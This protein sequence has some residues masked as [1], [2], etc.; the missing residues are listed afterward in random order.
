MTNSIFRS[1][2]VFG[3]DDTILSSAV[4]SVK[5]AVKKAKASGKVQRVVLHKKGVRL[6]LEIGDVYV[7]PVSVCDDPATFPTAILYANLRQHTTGEGMVEFSMGDLVDPKELSKETLKAFKELVWGDSKEPLLVFAAS[8]S[9][10]ADHQSFLYDADTVFAELRDVAYAAPFNPSLSSSFDQLRAV[11]E[12]SAPTSK[13]FPGTQYIYKVKSGEKQEYP[14]MVRGLDLA[15]EEGKDKKSSQTRPT[16][17]ILA[18]ELPKTEKEKLSPDEMSMFANLDAELQTSIVSAEE[19]GKR[20]LPIYAGLKLAAPAP[21]QAPGVPQVPGQQVTPA[22]SG[23]PVVAPPA[24]P[25][26]VAPVQPTTKAQP[27][28]PGAPTNPSPN[29]VHTSPASGSNA[30]TATPPPITVPHDVVGSAKKA[31]AADT[32]HAVNAFVEEHAGQLMSFSDLKAAFSK[33]TDKIKDAVLF[34]KDQGL[35]V[36]EGPDHVKIQTSTMLEDNS[37]VR[38]RIAKFIIKNASGQVWASTV[39]EGI[40]LGGEWT[41]DKD[42]GTEFENANDAHDEVRRHVL[43]S[44][45]KVVENKE[46]GCH[47]CKCKKANRKMAGDWFNPGSVLDTFYP[48]LRQEPENDGKIEQ[49]EGDYIN[50]FGAPGHSAPEATAGGQ[51]GLNQTPDMTPLRQENNFY[52]PEFARNFY[53]PHADI[54]G[55][56]LTPRQSSKKTA[57]ENEE[58]KQPQVNVTIP[59]GAFSGAGASSA[60]GAA[61]GAGEAAAGAA[62]ALESLAPLALLASGKKADSTSKPMSEPKGPNGAPAGKMVADYTNGQGVRVNV[63]KLWGAHNGRDYVVQSSNTDSLTYLTT[64]QAK[65]YLENDN[66]GNWFEG[67]VPGQE[68]Q[69]QRQRQRGIISADQRDGEGGAMIKAYRFDSPKP[70]QGEME[71]RSEA[72]VEVDHLKTNSNVKEIQVFIMWGGQWSLTNRWERS[73]PESEW[74]EQAAHEM[75]RTSSLKGASAKKADGMSAADDMEWQDR[76]RSMDEGDDKHTVKVRA[77]GIKPGGFVHLFDFPSN[78]WCE[79]VS[80]DNADNLGDER[81]GPYVRYVHAF[82]DSKPRVEVAEASQLEGYQGTVSMG[83]G[84][85]VIRKDG[86]WRDGEKVAS[87]KKADGA[88]SLF[89]GLNMAEEHP[90]AYQDEI[91][92]SPEPSPYN[93]PTKDKAVA[94]DPN[95]LSV[96]KFVKGLVGAYAAQLVGAFKYTGTPIPMETPFN[97]TIDMAAAVQ[98]AGSSDSEAARTAALAQLSSSLESLSDDQRRMILDGSFAQSAVWCASGSG[99]GGF[100]YEVFVRPEQI[101]GTSMKVRVITGRK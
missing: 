87:A 70:Y 55:S 84:I 9:N 64:E 28:T 25:P 14:Q 73:T 76:Q 98:F 80:V 46:C 48:S 85:R 67:T 33:V 27:T 7:V 10:I 100:T 81:F 20:S 39:L 79:V 45:A 52:G 6:D 13:V 32:V 99:V 23:Q 57:D 18:A 68:E 47:D 58:D 97:D 94:Q 74:D 88:L 91:V 82:R 36:Q 50:P 83:S 77:M 60:E 42:L 95:F 41:S 11:D 34:A 53:G 12:D 5:E 65:P 3:A 29:V 66:S 38:H 40:P 93:E 16:F 75:Y 17:R 2:Q 63:Y 44:E 43:A 69:R 35:I 8:W 92:Q 37:V 26:V 1:Y 4:D 62:G 90:Q 54:P 49:I 78:T 101:D 56:A 89:R 61:A 86:I 96:D 15:R 30:P 31:F 51:E 21:T 59:P 24:V 71:N 72:L 19:D 22:V